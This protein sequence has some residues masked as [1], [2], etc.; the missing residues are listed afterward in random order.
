MWVGG[1]SA[2]YLN[3]GDLTAERFVG[4]PFGDGKERRLYRS[5]D[6]VRRRGDGDIEYL[7]R[8]DNQ[9]KIRGYRIE[10]GEI[11]TVL[12]QHIGVRGAVVVASEDHAGDKRL[13]AYVVLK[14]SAPAVSDLRAFLKAKL[15]DYMLP[16]AFI[17]L[18]TLRS[19]PTAKLT[20]KRWRYRRVLV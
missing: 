19:R 5:V 9:V 2:S 1:S 16:T 11:E 14:E 12:A 6:L 17:F 18:D 15:P 20:A 7:G 10:L 13:V 8:I 3:R 4:H